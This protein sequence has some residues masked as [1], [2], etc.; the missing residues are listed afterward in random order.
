M[1][2]LVAGIGNVLLGDDGFGVEV[3]HRLAGRALPESVRVAEFGIRG[4]DLVF[5]LLGGYDA[6]ILVDVVN[7]G[8]SPGTLYVIEPRVA[9]DDEVGPDTHEMHPA[10]VLAL[11]EAMGGHVATMR[12]VGCEPA[13]ID[14]DE[15]TM[16]LSA[17]VA[18]AVEP[19]MAL[20][21]SIVAGLEGHADA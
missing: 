6:A 10:R 18:A 16:G 12:L 7:R 17:S 14:L 4:M 15:L 3:A 11:A 2:I 19:A 1:K 13:T 8:G 9:P 21:E 20:V 5:A